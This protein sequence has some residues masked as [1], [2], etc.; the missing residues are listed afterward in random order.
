M[1]LMSICDRLKILEEAL[2]RL[3]ERKGLSFIVLM[4]K[5]IVSGS[6]RLILQG[7]I[8]FVDELPYRWEPDGSFHAEDVISRK[9]QL[10]LVL[11]AYVEV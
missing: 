6:N 8:P 7:S 11:L 1:G 9:E 2:D 3:Q 10:I 4:V 5:G